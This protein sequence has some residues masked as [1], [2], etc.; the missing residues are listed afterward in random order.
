MKIKREYDL[1]ILNRER[2][3]AVTPLRYG[4]EPELY[5][6]NRHPA[7]H[8]HFGHD[9]EIRVG[10]KKFLRPLSFFLF[11]IR[12]CYPECWSVLVQIYNADALCKNIREHLDDIDKDYWNPKDE[13][14]MSLS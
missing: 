2:K 11:V 8:M 13:W 1:Y 7:S 5:R 14:E 4:Y 12:Q 10:T 6:E 9:S 3:D